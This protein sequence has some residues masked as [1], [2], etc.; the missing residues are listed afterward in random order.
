MPSGRGGDDPLPAQQFG[1]VLSR[2]KHSCGMS[3]TPGTVSLSSSWPSAARSP[4]RATSAGERLEVRAGTARCSYSARQNA[5]HARPRAPSSGSIQ[6]VVAL[7]LAQRLLDVRPRAAPRSI[8]HAPTSVW[9]TKQLAR[10]RAR[11]PASRRA[12]LEP[13]RAR[14]PPSRP[15]SRPAR[16]SAPARRPSAWCRASA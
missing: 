2:V 4:A 14:A 15:A 3:G 12:R 10:P 5:L 13:A 7:R 6:L 1:E 16:R 8:G 9:K 11:R